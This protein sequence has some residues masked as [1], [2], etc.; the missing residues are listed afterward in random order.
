MMEILNKIEEI[1]LPIV[2]NVVRIE[3]N[4]DLYLYGAAILFILIMASSLAFYTIKKVVVNLVLAYICIYIGQY[5]FHITLV[6]DALMLVLMAFFGPLA[7]VMGFIW[8]FL[9]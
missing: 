2:G 6:P 8:H 1:L 4:M 7:V 3:G 9:M 5:L